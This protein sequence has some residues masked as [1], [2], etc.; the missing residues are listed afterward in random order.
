[1]YLTFALC[2][3]TWREMEWSKAHQEWISK[4]HLLFWLMALPLIQS[5]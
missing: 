2:H 5:F 4:T 3:V 1:M